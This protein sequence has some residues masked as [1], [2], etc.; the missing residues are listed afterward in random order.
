V[1]RLLV[2][3]KRKG[4][5]AIISGAR[6]GHEGNAEAGFGA[7]KTLRAEYASTAF[8]MLIGG[9]FFAAGA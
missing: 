9:L 5:N 7:E 2:R 1:L 8:K 3:R 4:V 6:I